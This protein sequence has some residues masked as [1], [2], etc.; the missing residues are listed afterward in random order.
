MGVMEEEIICFCQKQRKL[1][2]ELALKTTQRI[3]TT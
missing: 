2:G 1:P 3:H